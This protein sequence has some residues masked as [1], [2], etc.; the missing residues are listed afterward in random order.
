MDT[1]PAPDSNS[2]ASSVAAVRQ[3]WLDAVRVGD[4]KRL[5][6]MVTG[7]VV[8]V[9]GNGR[10]GARQR[11]SYC[12]SWA[13]RKCSAERDSTGV[14]P[15]TGLHLIWLYARY[16]SS[17]VSGRRLSPWSGLARRVWYTFK[18][19]LRNLYAAPAM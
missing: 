6:A 4:V 12:N 13:R 9:H 18:Q 15:P 5:A 10:G 3:A 2:V 17:R 16:Q 7:N 14:D 8:V 11:A 1:F 19:L